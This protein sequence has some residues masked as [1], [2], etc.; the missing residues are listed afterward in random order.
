VLRAW[1][2]PV[3]NEKP[4]AYAPGRNQNQRVE[5][6]GIQS[7]FTGCLSFLWLLNRYGEGIITEEGRGEKGRRRNRE[8]GETKNKKTQ[9]VKRKT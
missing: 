4:G 8:E 7:F 3:V 9:N 6:P 2:G 1:T 5:L